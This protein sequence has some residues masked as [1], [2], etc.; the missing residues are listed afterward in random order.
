MLGSRLSALLTDLGLPHAANPDPARRELAPDGPWSVPRDSVPVTVVLRVQDADPDALGAA[1]LHFIEGN[2]P[3]LTGT[4]LPAS[5]LDVA[6]VPGVL[7]IELPGVSRPQLHESVPATH[8]DVVRTG[9]LG[10]DGHGVIIGVVDSGID[11]HHYSF[12]KPDGTTRLLSLLDTTAPY[13][14]QAGGGPNAGTFTISWQPPA[15]NGVSPPVQTTAPPLPFNATAAQVQ[16]A[17]VALAA[18]DPG[19]VAVT[20]GPLPGAGIV[21]SFQGQYLNKD[22][23]PLTVSSSVTPAPAVIAVARGHEYSAKDI[24]DRLQEPG[25]PFGSWD[26]DGHGSHVMGIAG[27]NGLN[28]GGPPGPGNCHLSGYYVGVAPGADLIAVKTTFQHEDSMRGVSYIFDRAAALTQPAVVNLSFGGETGAHDGSADQEQ[29][30]DQLL[31]TTPQGRAIVVAAGN[32]G[33]LFDVQAPGL[34]ANRGGGLHTLANIGANATTTIRFVI[35]PDDK[36]DDWFDF[37]YGG[38]GRLTIQLAAPAVGPGAA[39]QTAPVA[40]GDPAYTTPLAGNQLFILNAT[41]VSSTGRHNISMRIRPPAGAVITAG[42]W[43]ITLTETAGSPTDVDGWISLDKTDPHPRFSNE[44]Q[45]NTRTLTIPAT[46][47]NVITVAN[48]NHRDSKLGDSSSRGPTIDSRLPDVTKPDIAAPGTGI[49]SVLSGAS[50]TTACCKCC[51]DFYVAMSGTSMAAPHVTGIVALL[52]QR[53]RTLTFSDIRAALRNHADPPDP[54]TGPTLPNSD[55][56]AGVVNAEKAAQSIAAHA[57]AGGS[58]AGVLPLPAPADV[59]P[60]VPALVPDI[61]AMVTTGAGEPRLRDLRRAILATPAGQL[62]AGLISTHADEV[63]RLVNH[64]R[65]VTI[66]W[67][68]MHGPDLLQDVLRRADAGMT[69][70]DTVQGQPVATGLARLLDQLERAGSPRLREHIGQYRELLM[71]LPGLN[72]ADLGTLSWAG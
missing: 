32:D 24:N 22:V 46:A 29:R 44:D 69:L 60:R 49:T 52:L 30:Y 28:A 47:H 61:A 25:A 18:I 58:P 3:V 37:W 72:L 34:G 64:E 7:S 42:Y 39:P 66:A 21:V 56:G 4:V 14:L 70:P 5:V 53:N 8:A 9:P 68:R 11:I 17:L 38:A 1:G 41:S 54:I 6:E 51:Y 57:A 65:R 62:V 16:A 35:G 19:D 23:E 59:R 12:R 26:A 36:K 50:Q 40:P 63:I 48:Y 27:G 2:E 15:K 20:G 55:W 13:T 67:H 71:S 45:D 33:A 31:T 10:L 43:T